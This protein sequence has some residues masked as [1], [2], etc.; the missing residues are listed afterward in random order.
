MHSG[1][2]GQ[3]AFLSAVGKSSLSV[4]GLGALGLPSFKCSSL[5]FFLPLVKTLETSVFIFGGSTSMT[6]KYSSFLLNE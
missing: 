3:A 2:Q 4:A 5:D 1:P 6:Q